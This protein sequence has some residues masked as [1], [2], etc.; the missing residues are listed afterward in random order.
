MQPSPFPVNFVSPAGFGHGVQQRGA[1]AIS[2][3]G[4]AALPGETKGPDVCRY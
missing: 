2:R 3:I 4:T 1:V